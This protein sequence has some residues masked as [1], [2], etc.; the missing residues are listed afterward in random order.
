M[1][2]RIVFIF[3]CLTL[4]ATAQLPV[5]T[6]LHEASTVYV[7]NGPGFERDWLNHAAIE[8]QRQKRFELVAS[9]DTADLVAT[10]H[11]GRDGSTVVVPVPGFGVIGERFN[12]FYLDITDQSTGQTVWSDSREV[13]LAKRG[14]VLDLVKNLHKAISAAER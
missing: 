1:H 3:L 9:R 12:V 2:L 6:A 14:A 4:V 11:S 10:F 8:F 13:Q 7:Q 5:H